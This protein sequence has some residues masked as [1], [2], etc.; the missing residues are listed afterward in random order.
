MCLLVAVHAEAGFQ[1]AKHVPHLLAARVDML[2]LGEK[3]QRIV[4]VHSVTLE[5]LFKRLERVAVDDE[6]L[7]LVELDLLG[8]AWI[9]HGHP[10]AAIVEQQV[11]EIPQDAF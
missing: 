9:Q 1:R 6:Q 3:S 11:F 5:D 7:V 4:P 2:R 10:S 8:D